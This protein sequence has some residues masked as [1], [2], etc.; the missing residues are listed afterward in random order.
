VTVGYTLKV[1]PKDFDEVLDVRL[2]DAG[3]THDMRF[4]IMD[5]L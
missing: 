2:N 5:F 4:G 1:E 3:K